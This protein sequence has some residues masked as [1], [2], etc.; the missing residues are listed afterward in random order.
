MWKA[1]CKYCK[2]IQ[3]WC[4]MFFKLLRFVCLFS[5]R[6]TLA[7]LQCIWILSWHLDLNWS[8]PFQLAGGLFCTF[9]LERRS[10]V[11]VC[12]CKLKNVNNIYIDEIITFFIFSSDPCSSAVFLWLC[13]VIDVKYAACPISWLSQDYGWQQLI[14]ARSFSIVLLGPN[15]HIL[16]TFD[17]WVVDSYSI[18][19]ER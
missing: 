19:S 5:P 12:I 4:F 18:T 10:L 15:Y 1:I 13:A 7:L 6:C 2:Y 9:S 14:P 8:S 16:D 11:R 17:H 3:C